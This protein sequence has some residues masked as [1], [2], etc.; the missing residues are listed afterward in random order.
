MLYIRSIR[1]SIRII[2]TIHRENKIDAMILLPVLLRDLIPYIL[3]AKT[4]NAKLLH[5][6]TE[7]PFMVAGGKEISDKL[8]LN[9]YLYIILRQFDGIYVISNTLKK[10]FNNVLKSG[11]RVEV[12]N[13]IVDSGRFNGAELKPDNEFKYIAYCGKLNSEKDGVDILV[14]SYC[15][16]VTEGKIP[17][18][19]KLM[20]IGD[21]VSDAFRTSL[22]SIINEKNCAGNIIFTGK[23]EREKIPPLLNNASALALAR[24]YQ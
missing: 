18:V 20:L 24:P 2:K 3:L 21:F 14:E 22:Q 17:S 1:N 19:V 7:Y 15:R 5:E 8:R 12:I 9:I 10:Y 4:I 16:S 23:M 11:V 13:M 6:R